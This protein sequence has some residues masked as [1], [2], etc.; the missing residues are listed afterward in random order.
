MGMTFREASEMSRRIASQ[1][2]DK[3]YFA[4]A[5][6]LSDYEAG[7]APPRHVHKAITLCAMYGLAFSTFLEAVGL[8]PE[9]PEDQPIPDELVREQPPTGH[10]SVQSNFARAD[11]FLGQLLSK[12]GPVPFFLRR[13]LPFLSG[14][15]VPSVN[16]FFWVSD[17]Q[18]PLHPLLIDALAVVVDRHR[19]KAV[20]L[21]SRS[22][23]HQPLY[24]LLKRDGT[25][26]CGCCSLEDSTL[27]IHP[28][29]RTHKRPEHLRN[30]RDAEVI[31]EVVTIARRL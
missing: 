3:R 21:R 5:S 7:D 20:Y 23:W 15:R 10:G 17:D 29:S 19:R 2:A 24:V 12:S 8:D 16:D 11:G 31:G 27:V 14:L 30:Y 25:Y 6:S 26:V 28:H 4:A 9:N 1:L 18:E 22:L 13:S